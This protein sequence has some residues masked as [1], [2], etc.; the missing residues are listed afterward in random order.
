MSRQVIKH[1][2]PSSRRSPCYH[3]VRSHYRSG[4]VFVRSY[5][6]G[7]GATCAPQK[8]KV[9]G[10][11]T[12]EKPKPKISGSK[13]IY[14]KATGY[15]S[16]EFDRK[17][18]R[19]VLNRLK[20]RGFRYRPRSKTWGAKW[21]LYREE[22]AKEIAG[23]I[24]K[25]D[26]EINYARK[27]EIARERAEKH[28][29]KSS[30]YY[31]R[32]HKLMS[33]IPPGQPILVGHHSEKKHRRDLKRMDTWT[34]KAREEGEIADKYMRRAEKY[35]GL[36]THGENPVTLFN[37][38]KKLESEQR[39]LE[40]QI[41]NEPRS[42]WNKD[43]LRSLEHVRE[44]LEIDRAKYKASGGIPADNMTFKKGDKID[45]RF[46]EAT[47]IKVNRATLKVKF[48]NPALKSWNKYG[49]KL[50]KTDV[51]GKA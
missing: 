50:D 35:E 42:E 17:P 26:I 10:K 51:L 25:I 32:T 1:N 11:K 48:D 47:I 21:S 4:P 24:D 13:A 44:R 2:Y 3:K 31:D 49:Y 15:L 30:D 37:R 20:S 14:N 5:H 40:R 23:S 18:D 39:S 16:V 29:E 43:R 19:E 9:V 34:R 41:K 36:A 12:V 6:R 22:L 33:L 8:S 7:I 46:G 28:A 38:I 27:A 45:T